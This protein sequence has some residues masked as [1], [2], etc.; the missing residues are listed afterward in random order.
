M[1]LFLSSFQFRL[2]LS[3]SNRIYI[4]D[5]K[6]ILY[7]VRIVVF[8]CINVNTV[9]TDSLLDFVHVFRNSEKKINCLICILDICLCSFHTYKLS[10]DVSF[11]PA[12]D[13]VAY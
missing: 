12:K 5:M 7:S 6:Y 9:S 2:K 3:S 13:N 8:I 10:A 1:H 4:T 11:R